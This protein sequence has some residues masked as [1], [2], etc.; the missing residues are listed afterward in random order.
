[1]QFNNLSKIIISIVILAL[2]ALAGWHQRGWVDWPGVGTV[3]LLVSAV[4]A[5]IP[6]DNKKRDA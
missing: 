2:Y 4:A 6:N 3:A 5:Y 1:M